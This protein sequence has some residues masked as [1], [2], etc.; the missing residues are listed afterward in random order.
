M[1]EAQAKVWAAPRNAYKSVDISPD[2]LTRHS[3]R[4]VE[5]GVKNSD[6]NTRRALRQTITN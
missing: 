3:S 1:G 2:N 4:R 5:I 6:R